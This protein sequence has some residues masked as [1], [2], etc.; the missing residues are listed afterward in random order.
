MGNTKIVLTSYNGKD[1]KSQ[2]YCGETD[3]CTSISYDGHEKFYIRNDSGMEMYQLV[4]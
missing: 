1:F 4:K 3:R 2:T